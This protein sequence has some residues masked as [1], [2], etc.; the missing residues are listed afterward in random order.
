MIK[1]KE[2][3]KTFFTFD[4]STL[5]AY[6]DSRKVCN[7]AYRSFL[8]KTP[9]GC[10]EENTFFVNGECYGVSHFLTVS[11]IDGFDIK[12]AN[13]HLGLD[14]GNIMAIALVEGDDVICL[15]LVTGEVF[16]WMISCGD[17]EKILISKTF[18]MFLDMIKIDA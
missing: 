1:I 12:K 8:E 16:L 15:D 18:D 5:F 10:L 17:G 7:K 13:Q 9:F 14:K 11:K 3:T 6:L 2:E 4:K